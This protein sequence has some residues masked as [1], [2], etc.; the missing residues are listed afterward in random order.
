MPSSRDLP[1]PGIEPTSLTSPALAGRFFTTSTS[2]EVHSN[3]AFSNLPVIYLLHLLSNA[4]HYNIS[5]AQVRIFVCLPSAY[6]RA[7][8]SVDPQQILAE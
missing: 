1:D 5:S 2:W 7:W 3:S 8:H 6:N 4:S